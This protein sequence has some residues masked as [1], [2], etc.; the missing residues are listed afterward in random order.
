MGTGWS[1]R[2]CTLLGALEVPLVFCGVTFTGDFTL[3]N[4]K[5]ED[6]V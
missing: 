2:A 4:N 6:R 1:Y 3:G 5:S